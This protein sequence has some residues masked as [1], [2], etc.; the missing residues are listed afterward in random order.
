MNKKYVELI[1]LQ[2]RINSSEDK[3][4]KEAIKK[5][6]PRL[7]KFGAKLGIRTRGTISDLEPNQFYLEMEDSTDFDFR[8][9]WRVKLEYLRRFAS[10]EPPKGAKVYLRSLLPNGC[11]SLTISTEMRDIWV[12][13]YLEEFVLDYERQ[14]KFSKYFVSSEQVD[15]QR[16]LETV[17]LQLREKIE[18]EVKANKIW[19]KLQKQR[20]LAKQ[21]LIDLATLETDLE[22]AVN[23]INCNENWFQKTERALKILNIE[24]D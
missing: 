17:F 2:L 4:F 16:S 11:V 13:M 7:R 22:Y 6:N 18:Q 12:L 10:F 9:D 15:Q 14:D 21:C 23:E 8:E 19:E 1:E 3:A 5:L 20:S 24:K